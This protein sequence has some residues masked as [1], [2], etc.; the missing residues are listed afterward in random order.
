MKNKIMN[1]THRGVISFFKTLGSEEVEIILPKKSIFSLVL[2]GSEVAIITPVRLVFSLTSPYM[3]CLTTGLK[4]PIEVAS[5][6]DK[7]APLNTS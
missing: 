4:I 2:F 7:I 3:K 6:E 5:K 1:P